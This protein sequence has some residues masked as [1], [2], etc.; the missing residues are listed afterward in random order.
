M[1]APTRKLA[2]LLVL[3]LLPACYKTKMDGFLDSG[4]PG[5]DE[6]VLV[7]T[8]LYGIVPLNTVNVNRI[9]GNKRVYSTSSSV[10]GIGLLANFITIGLYTPMTVK[11]TCEA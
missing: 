9:C 1:L 8:I 6:R 10:A 2:L 5:H 7:H 11:V 4:S 3:L